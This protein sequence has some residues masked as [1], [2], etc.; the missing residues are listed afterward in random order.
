MMSV[1]SR[2]DSAQP[3]YLR[4]YHY[5]WSDWQ[6]L[7]LCLE[8]AYSAETPH[9]STLLLPVFRIPVDLDIDRSGFFALRELQITTEAAAFAQGIAGRT[10]PLDDTDTTLPVRALGHGTSCELDRAPVFR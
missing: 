8:H 1:P 10:L 6:R 9:L 7:P 2:A 5:F 4:K 3:N